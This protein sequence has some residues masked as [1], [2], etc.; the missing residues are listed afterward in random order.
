MCDAS[1]FGIGAAL[2][3]S[4]SGTNKMNFISTNSRLI[5]QAELRISTLMR[6]CTATI[7]TLTEYEFLLLG[8]KHPTDVFTDH[9]HIIFLFTQKPNPNHRI[10][11]FLIKFNEIP[12]PTYSL[13]SRKKT[14]TTRHT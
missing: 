9:K 6:E 4:H 8:S 3:K 14:C 11:Q 5:T 12:K 10:L 7:Y 13:D 1:N 2:F